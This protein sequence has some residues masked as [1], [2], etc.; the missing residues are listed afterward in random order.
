MQDDNEMAELYWLDAR[1]VKPVRDGTS[2]APSRASVTPPP[3][4]EGEPL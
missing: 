3:P 2:S 4:G 1:E